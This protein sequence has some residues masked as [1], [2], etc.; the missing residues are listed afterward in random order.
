MIAAGTYVA[1]DKGEIQL[2]FGWPDAF[3][4]NGI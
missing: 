1:K 4:R 3:R 2:L